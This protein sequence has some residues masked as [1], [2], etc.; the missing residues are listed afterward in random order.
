MTTGDRVMLVDET[1]ASTAYPQVG[2]VNIRPGSRYV[3]VTWDDGA[4]ETYR[5][6]SLRVVAGGDAKPRHDWDCGV[7]GEEACLECKA[8]QTEENYLGPCDARKAATV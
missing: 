7:P 4:R 6:D 5:Q 2:T 1:R 8:A 3:V